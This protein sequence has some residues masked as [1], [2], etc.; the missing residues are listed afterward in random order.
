MEERGKLQQRLLEE[1]RGSSQAAGAPG[2]EDPGAAVEGE[3]A[4]EDPLDAFMSDVT[5][6]LEQ[7]KVGKWGTSLL[8]YRGRQWRDGIC[9]ER[10]GWEGVFLTA[11]V[12]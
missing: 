11:Q 4:P 3:G 12:G 8:P 10:Q 1:E 9:V 2:G 7:S 5:V 6:Q